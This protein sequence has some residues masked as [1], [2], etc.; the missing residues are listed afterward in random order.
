MEVELILC[1]NI[2]WLFWTETF[3]LTIMKTGVFKNH[4]DALWDLVLKFYLKSYHES[5]QTHLLQI[6]NGCLK[7]NWFKM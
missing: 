2:D 6:E 1:V 3:G 7:K 4:S 5:T